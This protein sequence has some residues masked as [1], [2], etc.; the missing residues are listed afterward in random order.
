MWS[1]WAST[2]SVYQVVFGFSISSQYWPTVLALARQLNN[3]ILSP[4]SAFTL[5]SLAVI[6]CEGGQKVGDEIKDR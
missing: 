2:A 6:S 1:H 5:D 4:S 3:H